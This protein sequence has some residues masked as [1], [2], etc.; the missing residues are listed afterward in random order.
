MTEQLRSTNSGNR[1]SD[2]IVTAPAT[3]MSATKGGGGTY[4]VIP[5]KRILGQEGAFFDKHYTANTGI[6]VVIIV[7][8]ITLIYILNKITNKM[9][10]KNYF[11]ISIIRDLGN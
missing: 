3:I 4:Y 10:I 8:I 1:K 6:G 7:I 5:G 9:G 11:Q 2:R